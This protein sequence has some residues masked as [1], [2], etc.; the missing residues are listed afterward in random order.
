MLTN[1]LPTGIAL[2][3]NLTNFYDNTYHI[4]QFFSWSVTAVEC[5]SAGLKTAILVR[6]PCDDCRWVVASCLSGRFWFNVALK[7]YTG[8]LLLTADLHCFEYLHFSRHVRGEV[9]NRKLFKTGQNFKNHS[10]LH[11]RNFEN[12]ITWLEKTSH[13]V[14]VIHLSFLWRR[15]ICSFTITLGTCNIRV[16]SHIHFWERLE[17]ASPA[18]SGLDW[19]RQLAK[20]II[21]SPSYGFWW[22]VNYQEI[23]FPCCLSRH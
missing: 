15:L 10:A 13:I 22:K 9:L 23:K 5:S 6:C 14:S 11:R 18:I 20:V 4:N 21:T 19:K 1:L 2:I 12:N 3:R 7:N 8:S 17:S 16:Q